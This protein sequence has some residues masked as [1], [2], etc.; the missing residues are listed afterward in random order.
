MK[1]LFTG[2]F[3][4]LIGA[5]IVVA[6]TSHYEESPSIATVDLVSLTSEKMTELAKSKDEKQAKREIKIFGEN[7]ENKLAEMAAD[8]KVSIVIKPMV[9]AG[10]PDLTMELKRRLNDQFNRSNLKYVPAKVQ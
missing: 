9:V 8:Y 5:I 7:I 2:L 6:V 4:G 3:G 10:A 1:E